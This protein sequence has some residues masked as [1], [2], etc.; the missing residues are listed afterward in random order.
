MALSDQELERLHKLLD[1]RK[2]SDLSGLSKATPMQ[3]LGGDL[4][5]GAKA[6]VD[7]F[8]KGKQKVL[9]P[10]QADVNKIGPEGNIGTDLKAL[11]Q[12]AGAGAGAVSEELGNVTKTLIK[13]TL[14]QDQEDALKGTAEA[15]IA[16]IAESAPVQSLIEKYN[17][18]DEDTKRTVD[19]ALGTVS[20]GTD[21]ATFGAGAAIKKP[22]QEAVRVGVDAV[23]DASKGA[24]DAGKT[25]IDISK[26]AIGAGKD[27]IKGV[28]RVPENIAVNLGEKDVQREAIA[29][30][31]SK[32]A[33]QAAEGGIEVP[34]VHTV[35]D[36]AKGAAKQTSHAKELYQ[37]VKAFAKGTSKT[38]P[39]GIVGKPI[40]ARLK[41]LEKARGKVGQELGVVAHDLGDFT[42]SD[43]AS[44]VFNALKK[45]QG[46]SGLKV[47]K[48][49]VLDFADTV[50]ATSLTKPDRKA[51]QSIFMQAVKGGTGRSKHLLRQELFEVL[52]GQ[53]KSLANIT[54]TQE[55]AYQAVRESLSNLLE[56]KNARYKTLSNQYRKIIHPLSAMRK[57]MGEI[58]GASED[59]LNMQAGLLARRLT[60]FAKSNPQVRAILHD[61]D[62][63]L[64]KKMN[65]TF[66]VE[67][68]QDLYNV[69]DKYYDI[70][71]KTS[72]QGQ[73]KNAGADV[74]GLFNFI[75]KTVTDVG[76]ETPAVRQKALEKMFD[77]IFK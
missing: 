10:L 51:I 18:L 12:S 30:L 21:L 46:L 71:G 2:A 3:E 44:P 64:G 45:V 43:L 47:S 11:G 54:G 68:L 17:S 52:D 25:A 48:K 35:L 50:L 57:M 6:A 40:V 15:A 26:G 70:A 55:K 63:A 16:P 38:D 7:I 72:F 49:G 23:A 74:S 56:S 33:K 37:A 28:S 42:T 66:S 69:F 67:K 61:M 75:K 58:P 31:P 53:K 41:T 77:E 1:T 9:A 29:Q 4:K 32:V 76:G 60:S 13:S 14:G 19:A 34:D 20:L 73:I 59:I 36:V 22:V 24:I 27:L 39:V 62:H 65:T 5:Q 8:N